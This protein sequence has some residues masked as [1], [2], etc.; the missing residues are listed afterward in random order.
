MILFAGVDSGSTS[1]KAVLVNIVPS[2]NNL[3]KSTEV[4]LHTVLEK[5]HAG[6]DDLTAIVTTGYGR[7]ITGLD[8]KAMSE[9]TC[10]ARGAHHLHPSARTVI[11]IGGQDSKAIKV[12]PVGKV[13]QF[14]MNDKCAA[15]TGRFLERIA[16][17]LEL[18]LEKMAEL[19]IHSQEKSSISSTCTVFA[20]TEVISKISNGEPIE[21]IVKGLHNALASRI[22]T[23]AASLNIEKDIFVCGGGAKNAGLLKEL[24]E[25]I[26]EMVVTPEGDP[27]L[28]P[29][30]GAALIAWESAGER[31]K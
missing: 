27:R 2:G 16:A 22:Y 14:S 25:L 24:E 5:A 10:C 31:T 13:V 29:S 21:Q 8:T 30:I 23:L 15:G 18:D 9:I 6:L 4:A 20:E 28:V 7:F 26:G 3:R 17:S 1:T 12:N 19:S 11:D